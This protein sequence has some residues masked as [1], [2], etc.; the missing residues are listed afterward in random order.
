MVNSSDG[1]SKQ[2]RKQALSLTQALLLLLCIILLA[3]VFNNASTVYMYMDDSNN[4]NEDLAKLHVAITT[5]TNNNQHSPETKT[6]TTWDPN[7]NPL[8]I[9]QGKAQ[10]LPS[11]RIENAQLDKARRK[12][13]GKGDKEHLGGFSEM[14]VGGISPAVFKYL[15]EKLGVHSFLDIG[16]GRGFSTS[17]F[18]FHGVRVMCAEGSHDAIERTILPDPPNQLV[19]HDFSRGPWWPEQTYDAAWSVEFLEHVNVQF[20]YNYVQAFRKAAL[21]FVT[22]SSGNGWHHVEVHSNEWWIQKYEA[23]GFRYSPELTEQ[24]KNIAKE[25]KKAYTA[26]NG[27]WY[28]GF[29]IRVNMKVFVNPVVAALPQHAHL[30]PEFGC[31]GGKDPKTG[32][33]INRECAKENMETPLDPSFYPL[34]LTPEMDEEWNAWVGKHIKH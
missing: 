12:Y 16:C 5:S 27:N 2:R 20:H 30:F 9:P 3:L 7:V 6:T 1:N 17:W 23:Y 31:F 15:V 14:D 26:P 22:S 18:A 8:A 13:G 32:K 25:N 10:N 21:I 19:E 11:I 29:Y 28:D 4:Q 24:V 34:K 33:R